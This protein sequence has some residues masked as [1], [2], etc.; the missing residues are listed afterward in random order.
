M[1]FP[2]VLLEK[3]TRLGKRLELI[4]GNNAK[5]CEY[6][7]LIFISSIIP[8]YHKRG[9]SVLPHCFNRKVSMFDVLKHSGLKTKRET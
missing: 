5:F 6:E 8:L 9:F 4:V 7:S 3:I 1:G 2:P